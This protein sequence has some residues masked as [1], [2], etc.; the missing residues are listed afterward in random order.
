M[1][2]K[3]KD[4]SDEDLKK[5]MIGEHLSPGRAKLLKVIKDDETIDKVWTIDG[6]IHCTTR[7][8]GTKHVVGSPHDLFKRLG[9]SEDKLKKSGLFI[10]ISE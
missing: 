9:W 6:N 2:K 3:L 4:S 7:K 1:G 10:D 5:V 8:D